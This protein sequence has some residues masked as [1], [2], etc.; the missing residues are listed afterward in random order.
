MN[1]TRKR[2]TPFSHEHSP[3][4]KTRS[5]NCT[6]NKEWLHNPEFKSWLAQTPDN[7]SARC[8]VCNKTFGVKFDGI[9][10]VKQHAKGKK[11]IFAMQCKK[12]SNIIEKF[13]PTSRSTDQD[14]VS[15]T[16]LT[17]VFHA[18]QHHH[19]YLSTDCGMKLNAKLFHDSKLSSKMHLGRTKM[20]SLVSNVLAP[21]AIHR[22]VDEIKSSGYFA[23]ATDASNKG[24]RK[25]FPLAVRYFTKTS[26]LCDRLLDFYEDPDESATGISNHLIQALQALDL[27][28]SNVIAY[29]A[30]NASVNY[31]KTCSVYKKL[32]AIQPNLIQ[33]NCNCHVI[34]NTAKYALKTLS[35]D[36][37][38]LV[39]KVFNEFSCSAKNV[40]ELKACFDFTHQEYHKVLRHVPTRWL[41]LFAAVERLLLNWQAIKMYFLECGEENCHTVIW[42]FI[43]DQEDG[44][45]STLTLPECY[46]FF[47][48]SFMAFFSRSIK[49]LEKDSLTSPELYSVMLD[50]QKQLQNRREDHFFGFRVNLDLPKLPNEQ[51]RAFKKEA[52]R[53]FDRALEYLER[54]FSFE[55]SPFKSFSCFDFMSIPTLDDITKA[56]EVLQM[57][58]RACSEDLYREFCLLKTAMPAIMQME[59][60][61]C[62][63]KWLEFFKN[64]EAPNL[65]CIVQAVLA[66]P[67]SNAF[68]ERVFSVMNNLWT[69]ER[70]R[71]SLPIVKSELCIR[72]NLMV[73]CLQFYDM[74]IKNRHLLKAVRS[75]SKYTFKKCN[76]QP[77]EE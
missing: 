58:E 45:S 36:V 30:D 37:E 47:V 73:P 70:N 31:G 55:M 67:C 13:F 20:E 33:A 28:V 19:S 71:L 27:S 16:E 9:D 21:Y 32:K 42:S 25:C 64:T 74:V 10:A 41:S 48:H 50:V 34:H 6:F 5:R 3:P 1:S 11:H 18:V 15:A 23:L 26:G 4:R 66:V 51:Q 72:Y 46:L 14:V 53:C 77:I 40:T 49:T 7:N 60:L 54:W 63:E 35:Y 43:K 76:S 61:S 8:T 29:T 52:L 17:Q 75:N 59:D 12:K 24:N 68:V 22:A 38:N 2:S 69:D 39:I 65:L 44:M 57:N 62:S 56:C